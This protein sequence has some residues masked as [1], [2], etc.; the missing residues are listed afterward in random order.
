[1]SLDTELKCGFTSTDL[2]NDLLHGR[3]DEFGNPLFS[4]AGTF[5]SMRSVEPRS[6]WPSNLCKA[7]ELFLDHGEFRRLP[8]K[9]IDLFVKATEI[10]TRLFQLALYVFEFANYRCGLL[11][12]K[13]VEQLQL[14][15]GARSDLFNLVLTEDIS[16]E[17]QVAIERDGNGCSSLVENLNAFV[18]RTSRCVAHVGFR[19]KLDA[20]TT[21]S[22]IR[23][24]ERVDRA[25]SLGIYLRVGHKAEAE[26]KKF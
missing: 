8:T 6:I 17:D 25:V 26:A 3:E 4:G 24:D 13:P 23:L 16:A 12:S 1:M 19:S 10:Y 15:G 9:I 18:R 11:F 5:G 21:V 22:E 20:E 14:C 2:T 7:L